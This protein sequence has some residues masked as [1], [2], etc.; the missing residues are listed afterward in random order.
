MN[1]AFVNKKL[2]VYFI[3]QDEVNVDQKII[4][5]VRK[6]N[7]LRLQ[8]EITKQSDEV[9]HERSNGAQNRYLIG[10]IDVTK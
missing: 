8:I 2:R 1:T 10:K 3:T 7:L 9:A 5:Q 4:K 6:F